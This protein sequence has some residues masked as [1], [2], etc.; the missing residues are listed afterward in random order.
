MPDGKGFLLVEFGGDTKQQADDEAR[1]C[2]DRL[3]ALHETPSMKLFDNPAQEEML[4]KVREGGLGSTAW[5]PGHPD[6]WPGWEDS[7]VPPDKIHD[8]LPKLRALMDKYGYEASLYGHFGQGC[9]HCRIPFDLYTAEGVR[10]FRDF[11][12]E[13]A[14]LVVK[15]GGSL[16]GEHGDGQA[17]AELLPKMYGE[18]LVAAFGE[19]KR[20]WDPDL[21][22]NPGKVVDPYP[23]DSNLRVGP[24]YRPPRPRT[25]FHFTNDQYSFSRAALRCVGVGE[26]RRSEGGVMC[27]SYRVTRE[28]KHSTRGR[29]HL[30][31]EMLNGEVL[32]D[33]WRSEEVRDA[34]DLCLA[35]KGCKNDCPVNVDMATYKAEFLSHY[36]EGRLRPRHAYAM[37]WIHWWAEL[38]A[39][40]PGVANFVS[41]TPVLRNIAKWLGGIDQRRQ[42]PPFATQ[43]F[44]AWW[45][46]RGPRGLTGSP[47]MVW[48]DTFTNHFHPEIGQA[49]VEVLESLGHSVE[50]P[51]QSLCCG[52]PLY[53]F[54]MLDTAQRLLRDILDTL[55]P[56]LRDGIPIVVLEP[57]CLSVF[58]DELIGLFPHDEDAQR[59]KQAACSLSEFLAQQHDFDPPRIDRRAIVHAHCHHRS[60][61]GFEGERALLEKMGLDL[62]MPEHGCC[63]M[64]GSFGFECGEHY[65]VA[66]ACGEQKLL[67]AVREAN[68]D[69][70]VV[71]DGFS[72]HEQIR[73]GTG[74]TP[75]HLAQ[76]LHAGLQ[77]EGRLSPPAQPSSRSSHATTLLALEAGIVLTTV[78]AVWLWKGT[79][80]ETRRQDK[81][82]IL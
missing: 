30:L 13:A 70:L 58:R 28:E 50:V 35:C 36:Y 54:G 6:S 53:D 19:F 80:H 3:K 76:L 7:A 16:S 14:D 56:A 18:E 22:M 49:C 26:C 15:F 66:R 33:G 60:V 32:T 2:M 37:G 81:R 43:T 20:I 52:R 55:R 46:A 67:P 79:D 24:D 51:M 78:A 73:Q 72:C 59:L 21:R 11:M 1:K 9:V 65:D 62:E 74:R 10:K 75:L 5:V 17:R 23:L 57:S 42:M 82:A 64:A 31:F 38:A 68:D 4:W 41:Q 44:Q 12:N 63:G 71:A 29:A 48:A 34:L 8:Y 47:V 39:W 77:A 69:T 27:P 40:L 45:Q 25:H 61:I